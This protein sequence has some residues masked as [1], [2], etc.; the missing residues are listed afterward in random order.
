MKMTYEQHVELGNALRAF[1]S[2][3]LRPWVASV[4]TKNSKESRAVARLYLETDRL[5][6]IMD[7]IVIRDYPEQQDAQH[8][9]FGYHPVV[10]P[11]A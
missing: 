1:R 8:I 6:N 5:K 7:A 9:Y 3:L 4:V 10:L 2:V 11:N